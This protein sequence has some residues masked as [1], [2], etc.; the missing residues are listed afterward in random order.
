MGRLALLPVLLLLGCR[1]P[2]PPA[3]S[4]S[5]GTPSAAVG[6]A[7]SRALAMQQA[8]T[9]TAPTRGAPEA[10]LPPDSVRGDFRRTCEAVAAFWQ[11]QPVAVRTV[12]SLIQPQGTETPVSAC[13]V[14]MTD[15]HGLTRLQPS[16]GGDTLGLARTLVSATG[17]GWYHLTRLQAD[18]PAGEETQF[19]RAG[20]RCAVI[21]SWATAED[22][23]GDWLEEV[24]ACWTALGPIRLTD[25][26]P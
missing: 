4:G 20:V 6:Q 22:D 5:R 18:G 25:T 3:R 13:V 2:V 15:D 17:P 8:E 16:G 19:Q 11:P 26:A 23:P 1:H 10:K 12:D 14:D 9:S 24:T 7:A 21:Q